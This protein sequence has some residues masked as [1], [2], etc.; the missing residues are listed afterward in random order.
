MSLSNDSIPTTLVTP[1]ITGMVPNPPV[2]V[3]MTTNVDTMRAFFKDKQVTSKT[4]QFVF[5]SNN[6]G[7]LSLV[8]N[9]ANG[10]S[11]AIELTIVS[12]GPN[13]TVDVLDTS[14]N[15]AIAYGLGSP[16]RLWAG[17]FTMGITN[18]NYRIDP[19]QR[20]VITIEFVPHPLEDY[21]LPRH[22][23]GTAQGDTTSLS[24][25]SAGAT[26]RN[27][28]KNT[29]RKRLK[30]VRPNLDPKTNSETTIPRPMTPEPNPVDP[31]PGDGE[32]KSNAQPDKGVVE[33]EAQAKE[34][35]KVKAPGPSPIPKDHEILPPRDRDLDIWYLREFIYNETT[36][37]WVESVESSLHRFDT[38]LFKLYYNQLY[39]YQQ[40]KGKSFGFVW[41][42]EEF[43]IAA[44]DI[45]GS[46][47]TRLDS[48]FSEEFLSFSKF[49]NAAGLDILIENVTDLDGTDRSLMYLA[50]SEDVRDTPYE[51]WFDLLYTA[52]SEYINE[53]ADYDLHM[54]TNIDL[55]NGWV[56]EIEAID[57]PAD[58]PILF[59]G[60][61]R[62]IQTIKGR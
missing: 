42:N 23:G 43:N 3:V 53:D 6:S 26:A 62:L 47:I 10:T 31:L 49:C 2:N 18:V 41:D 25:K 4:E 5:N 54:E 36:G 28:L 46:D 27:V 58:E 51:H 60:P 48:P 44:F 59:V 14:S 55:L 1:P 37:E 16:S 12:P 40:S 34:G 57:E 22:Y 15:F 13:F 56:R 39:H 17:P 20:D 61:K 45:D 32:F 30:Q 38:Y 24:K 7:F 21:E 35:E 33:E 11:I 50:F 8:H 52:Y 29:N 9:I 19:G